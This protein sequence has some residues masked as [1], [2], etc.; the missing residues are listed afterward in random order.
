MLN[1]SAVERVFIEMK[2]L[3]KGGCSAWELSKATGADIR[4]IEGD[5]KEFIKLGL[6]SGK[7]GRKKKCMTYKL[8]HLPEFPSFNPESGVIKLLNI[9]EIIS[10]H[11][12]DGICMEDIVDESMLT[13]GSV[14]RYVR[15][16]KAIRWIKSV[17]AF[18]T[19]TFRKLPMYKP[20]VKLVNVDYRD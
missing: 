4:T 19:G 11:R 2:L 14:S 13:G 5:L 6:V 3:A 16:L 15:I 9:F 10:R 7:T 12:K 8:H 17:K 18:K 1:K 20:M